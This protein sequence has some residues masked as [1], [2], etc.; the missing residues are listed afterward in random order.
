VHEEVRRELN[1]VGN[2]TS[3]ARDRKEV[4]Y[5]CFHR[6]QRAFQRPKAFDSMRQMI[7]RC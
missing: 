4:A 1:K 6:L 5:D 7:T 3:G 2:A